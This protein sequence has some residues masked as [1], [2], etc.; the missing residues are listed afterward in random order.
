MAWAFIATSIAPS[1][2]PKAKR[3]T[4]SR[5]GLGAKARK[6]KAAHIARAMQITTRRLPQ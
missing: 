6:G 1:A 5:K 3:V 4:A 2:A